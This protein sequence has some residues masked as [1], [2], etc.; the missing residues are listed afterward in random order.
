MFHP[1]GHLTAVTSISPG[2]GIKV[3]SF[4]GDWVVLLDQDCAKAILDG[5]EAG[6]GGMYFNLSNEAAVGRS[7]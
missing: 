4:S 5:N 3:P 6:Y 2:R 7:L 1:R